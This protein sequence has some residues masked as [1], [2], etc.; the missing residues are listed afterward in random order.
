MR[1]M[2]CISRFALRRVRGAYPGRRLALPAVLARLAV[3]T[4]PIAIIL[5]SAT[6][7]ADIL[8]LKDGT[9][10]EG[11]VVERSNEQ[12]IFEVKGVGMSSVLKLDVR[13]VVSIVSSPPEP[14]QL[15]QN[16]RQKLA[17]AVEANTAAAFAEVGQWAQDNKLYENA[18]SAYTQARQLAPD[19]DAVYGFA[20]AQNLALANSLRA[21]RAML[22]GLAAKHPDDVRITGELARLDQ[23]AQKQVETALRQALDL[24]KKGD[25][26]QAISGMEGLQRLDLDELPAKADIASNQLAGMSFGRLLADARLHQYCASCGTRAQSGLAPCGNCAGTG[27]VPKTRIVEETAKDP[28][29]GIE[30][31]RV[32]QVEYQAPCPTCKGFTTTVCRACDGA[33]V[34]LGTVGPIEKP[35]VIEGLR[36]RIDFLYEKL[37]RYAAEPASLHPANLEVV[38]LHACRLEYYFQQYV[39]LSPDIAGDDLTTLTERRMRL[40]NLLRHTSH[41]YRNRDLKDYEEIVKQQL[42]EL[43]RKEIILHNDDL[44]YREP[45]DVG[46]TAPKPPGKP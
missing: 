15:A 29:T 21:A 5:A 28:K 41:L 16:F 23:Q 24:Y 3:W 36:K 13:E 12:I 8:T 18:V 45:S 27:K 44:E 40:K 38:H 6:V 31:R 10:Y 17:A 11:R 30:H 43:V 20:A 7:H 32:Y 22:K 39:T 26:R 14:A 25:V 9:T 34:E 46:S 19:Q 33:G 42:L 4:F 37:A 35:Y 1:R 2:R